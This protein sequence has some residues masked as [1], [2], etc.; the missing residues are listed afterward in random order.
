MK[1]SKITHHNE[2]RI[3]VEFPYNAEATSKVKQIPDTRWSRTL[4]AW[5]IPYTKEAFKLL[6]SLFP[7]VEYTS[8]P[9]PLLEE[10]GAIPPPTPR[11]LVPLAGKER[12]AGD[13]VSTKSVIKKTQL[14]SAE[15]PEH[16][17]KENSEQRNNTTEHHNSSSTIERLDEKLVLTKNIQQQ[18]QANVK[19]KNVAIKK[20]VEV[21]I[22][23]TTKRIF[24]QLPKNDTD[25]QFLKSFRY[26]HWDTNNR[27]WIIP[28]YGKNLELLKSYFQ[29]RTVEI[30]EQQDEKIIEAKSSLSEVGILKTLNIQNRIL[31]I[32]FTYNRSLIDAIKMLP[33]CRWN[34]SEN[35]WT[36]PYNDQNQTKLQEIASDQGLKFV[37][38]VTS[39]TEGTPRQPKHAEYLRCPTEY[40]EKL[41]ELRYSI[42]TL[43]VYT[44]LFEEFL[45]YYPAKNA[46]DISEEEIITF[47]R[48]LV[49]E[50]KISTSYQ[51]QSI[52]A[53]KFYYERVLGGKRKIYL[54][55]RPRKENYLPEVLSEEEVTAILKSITNLKHKA[56]IMTIYSGGLRISELINLKVKDIDSDRMQIKVTQSKGKKDRYT[57]LSKKTLLI[58]RQ[59][60]KEYKPKE[61]LFEGVSGQQYT[62]SSIYNIFT[63]ALKTAKITKKVSIHSLRHSFA[64]HLLENGT[65]LRYIQSLL[66]HSSSKTTEIYT[67]ITTKGFDQIKNPMD[68]LD[69]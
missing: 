50:R 47:M 14:I 26:I 63:K 12:G 35:C 24:V 52:N 67:H 3:R 36:V 25:T 44:D 42:N 32:Y 69:I 53:I 65:D 39:K 66:G 43:N 23:L 48:Y 16:T 7:E 62:D 31:R 58:L 15:M 20:N 4:R 60:F 61:W 21:N 6:K 30:T 64:T 59:Y 68:K 51:N 17:P 18:S 37:Y 13:E 5:H 33:M 9:T 19:E 49:N 1:A 40:T 41:K 22:V 34:S 45:N 27:Q 2:L 29:S 56:L 10:R 55:E 54:I 28:N 38:E 46:E 8:P 57:L 11:I